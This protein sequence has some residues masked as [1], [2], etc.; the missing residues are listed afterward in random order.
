MRDGPGREGRDGSVHRE[1]DTAGALYHAGAVY[2]GCDPCQN[3]GEGYLYGLAEAWA[4]LMESA[5]HVMLA[6]HRSFRQVVVADRRVLTRLKLYKPLNKLTRPFW[7]RGPLA[8]S[9]ASGAP[10]LPEKGQ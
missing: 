9:E 4:Y 8:R 2:R 1:E 3:E 5:L 10:V 7:E 6:L